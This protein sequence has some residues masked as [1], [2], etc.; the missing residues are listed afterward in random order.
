LYLAAEETASSERE[1]TLGVGG[2]TGFRGVRTGTR[3]GVEGTHA[4]GDAGGVVFS[5][6]GAGGGVRVGRGAS[7]H[8]A[9]GVQ[10]RF[11]FGPRWGLDVALEAMQGKSA[12]GAYERTS[13]PLSVT[14]TYRFDCGG[15][16]F[17]LLSGLGGMTDKV[18]YLDVNRMEI[19]EEVDVAEFH[20][21]AGIEGRLG[22]FGLGAEVR[23]MALW[24]KKED[25]ASAYDAVPKS[26]GGGQVN[27]VATYYF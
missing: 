16:D 14:G 11:R 6:G 15:V 2:G 20:V 26:A 7:Q 8:R 25:M 23:A 13:I 21:G 18:K 27:L 24:R 3:L 5:R 1:V 4:L 19:E 17:Y 10:V 12:G 9:G 22:A